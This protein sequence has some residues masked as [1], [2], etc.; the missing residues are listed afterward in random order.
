MFYNDIIS[1][2]KFCLERLPNK[3][4]D[5]YAKEGEHVRLTCLHD[6]RKSKLFGYTWSKHSSNQHHRILTHNVLPKFRGNI[7]YS[8][9]NKDK[10][11]K[12]NIFIKP[13]I[14][15]GDLMIRNV[16]PSDE[17]DYL[18]DVKCSDPNSKET[19]IIKLHVEKGKNKWKGY[20]LLR[21]F[22]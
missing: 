21:Q 8:E 4:R 10:I 2:G 20:V 14:S 22:I 13:S 15:D 9:K 12:S 3:E 6:C 19:Q 1:K 18:C 7:T 5:E 17:G 11:D 16:R